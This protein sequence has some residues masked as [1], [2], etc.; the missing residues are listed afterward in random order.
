MI[1]LK[2]DESLKD[3]GAVA[4]NPLV[5]VRR[6]DW[7]KC[8]AY[9]ADRCPTSG[10]GTGQLLCHSNPPAP[11]VEP[12]GRRSLMPQGRSRADD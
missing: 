3:E 7:R 2:I 8:E 6:D 1:R 9:D 5:E 11:P 4:K 10:S 12:P